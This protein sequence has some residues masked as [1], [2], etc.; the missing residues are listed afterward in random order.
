MIGLV[1]DAVLPWLFAAGAF[2][3]CAKLLRYIARRIFWD[4]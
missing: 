2:I 3:A 4:R 1:F